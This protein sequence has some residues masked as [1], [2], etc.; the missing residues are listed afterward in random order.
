MTR[1]QRDALGDVGE[2]GVIEDKLVQR[3]ALALDVDRARLHRLHPRAG[4]DAIAGHVLEGECQRGHRV[5]ASL[6]NKE[7]AASG[8]HLEVT[9]AD[10]VSDHVQVV[11]VQCRLDS[12]VIQRLSWDEV[13]EQSDL[14]TPNG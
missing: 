12:I 11:G 3:L 7:L 9:R 2:L 6:R 1:Q 14:G 4:L 8:K 13:K 5:S 10:D